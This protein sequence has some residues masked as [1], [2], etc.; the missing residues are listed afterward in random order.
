MLG[1]N[2]LKGRMIHLFVWK[3]SNSSTPRFTVACLAGSYRHR[4]VRNHPGGL[5]LCLKG[6]RM[7][8]D[9][10]EAATRLG[11]SRNFIDTLIK[12]G[13]LKAVKLGTRTYRIPED[14]IQRLIKGE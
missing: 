13:E 7:M 12:R 4:P 2:F 14:E 1:D 6:E 8:I 5:S 10:D 11:V 9:K 3:E